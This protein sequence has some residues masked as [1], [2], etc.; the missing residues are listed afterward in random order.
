MRIANPKLRRLIPKWQLGLMLLVVLGALFFMLNSF[1][2]KGFEQTIK[3]GWIHIINPILYLIVFGRMYFTYGKE[4]ALLQLSSIEF[5]ENEVRLELYQFGKYF[6]EQIPYS[7]LITI[8]VK[9]SKKLGFSNLCITQKNGE[10][11]IL[12]TAGFSYKENQEIKNAQAK[13]HQLEVA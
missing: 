5:T 1:Y 3:N 13:V 10:E 6:I 7:E 4:K 11:V 9:Q 2:S 12:E 8:E